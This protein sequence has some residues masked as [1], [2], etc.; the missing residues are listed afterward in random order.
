MDMGTARMYSVEGPLLMDADFSHSAKNQHAGLT[1]EGRSG[2]PHQ[3]RFD[4]DSPGISLKQSPAIT[5][6]EAI[7][8]APVVAM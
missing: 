8:R 2:I 1:I 6:V 4:A 5:V 3:L 7:D